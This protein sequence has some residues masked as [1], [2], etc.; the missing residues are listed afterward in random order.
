VFE[1]GDD[2]IFASGRLEE[3][4]VSLAMPLIMELQQRRPSLTQWIPPK[5][6]ARIDPWRSVVT[7]SVAIDC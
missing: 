1:T 5:R 4:E 2:Y 6:K 7:A 3:L